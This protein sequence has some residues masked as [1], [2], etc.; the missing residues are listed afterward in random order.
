[1]QV[2]VVEGHD[3][4][5]RALADRWDVAIVTSGF[6][7]LSILK[8][9][10]PGLPI[11]FVTRA[12]DPERAL[13]AVRQGAADCIDEASL[14]DEVGPVIRRELKRSRSHGRRILDAHEAEARRIA[15][16]LHDQLGQL[17]AVVRLGLVALRDEPSDRDR[18][19]NLVGLVDD[20]IDKAR[21]FAHE[22]WPALLE[23]AGLAPALRALAE[24]QQ[25]ATGIA[26][27][28]TG[29]ESVRLAP[30]LETACYRIAQEAMLN[31]IRHARCSRIDVAVAG[32]EHVVE[33]RV[34]DDGSGFDLA[35]ALAKTGL[36]LRAMRERAELAK[37]ALEIRSGPGAGT[38]VG[39][40][41]VVP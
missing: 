31:A 29:E 41:V 5:R 23:I 25:H 35:A 12:Y 34:T 16:E 20:A 21:N 18:V 33:V 22:L 4:L 9:H 27:R 10:A 30:Q 38:T 6:A 24:R 7:P 40:R 14:H 37:A 15:G 32:D 28:V 13:E 2:R 36:G 8:Q 17:L 11:L 19:D 1:M 3:A 26:I 39:V